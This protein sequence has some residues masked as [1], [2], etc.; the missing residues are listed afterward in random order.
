MWHK[1]HTRYWKEILPDRLAGKIAD[2][3]TYD[4]LN[5]IFTYEMA[6]GYWFLGRDITAVE[7]SFSYELNGQALPEFFIKTFIG[8][9][10]DFCGHQDHGLEIFSDRSFNRI[11]P[12]KNIGY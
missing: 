7:L 12:V 5:Y 10:C 8:E 6:E 1:R 4:S 11:G 3:N 9:H 2:Y